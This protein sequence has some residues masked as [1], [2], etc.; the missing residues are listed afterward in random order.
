MTYKKEMTNTTGC[1]LCTS[2]ARPAGTRAGYTFHRCT[3]C[4]L[5]FVWPVP[6][7][8]LRIY[9]DDYFQGAT[10]GFGYV[11][12]DSDKMPME[13]TFQTYLDRLEALLPS[14]RR[15]LFDIGAATGFFLTLARDRGWDVK[16][17]EP[18]EFAAARAREK[19]LDVQTGIFDNCDVDPGSLDAVTM[20]DVIEH[21]PDPR[22]A[23]QL[24]HQRLR[25]GGI[26]AI[27]T[28]DSGSVIASLLGL[29]WPLVVPPEHLMLFH[30][31]SLRYLLESESFAIT[32][33]ETLGKRF[34]LQYVTS[35]LAHGQGNCLW[36]VSKLLRRSSLGQ[37]GISI[38]LRDNVTVFARSK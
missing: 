12:Y 24:I 21:L 26:L 20:W 29:R 8:T 5:L 22:A 7:D 28:P 33:M 11:D 14:G 19:G 13:R 31:R 1:P 35:V 34:T 2:A 17:V 32:G 37:L 36:Q 4:L 18:S 10:S 6:S 30:R 27:N 38:N 23:L 9:S 25:P 3:N 16:G 15:S